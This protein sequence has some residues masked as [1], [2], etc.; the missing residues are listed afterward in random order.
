MHPDDI[1]RWIGIVHVAA[2]ATVGTVFCATWAG[3]KMLRYF[4]LWRV[5]IAGYG[6]HMADQRASKR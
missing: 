4:D 6:R 3:W 1:F 2:Y 5:V